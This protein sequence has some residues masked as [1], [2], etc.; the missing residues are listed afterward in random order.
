MI[1]EICEVLCIH[2]VSLS[3]FLYL[4]VKPKSFFEMPDL[5]LVNIARFVSDRDLRNMVSADE[6][7]RGLRGSV[8][9]NTLRLQE[10][11]PSLQLALHSCKMA[12]PGSVREVIFEGPESCGILAI[13]AEPFEEIFAGEIDLRVDLWQTDY[14]PLTDFSPQ[15][16]DQLP[17][18]LCARV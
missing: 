13:L 14:S 12:S 10:H 1:V 17:V 11:T 3:L 4:Q 6:R 18:W 2:E 9:R 7:M 15:I 16:V 8:P 5:A